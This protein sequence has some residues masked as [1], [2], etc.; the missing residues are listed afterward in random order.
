VFVKIPT[1]FEDVFRPGRPIDQ[2]K[3]L[4]GREQQVWDFERSLGRPGEHI[5]VVGYRGAGKTSLWQM[6]LK[7]RGFV[8][9]TCDSRSTFTHVFGNLLGKLGVK[10]LDRE[11]SQDVSKE[12]GAKLKLGVLEGGGKYT[13]SDGTKETTKAPTE[14]NPGDVYELL[15]ST[16]VK[17]PILVLDE[18]DRVHGT[19]KTEAFIDGIADLMKICSDHSNERDVK[20]VVVGTMNTAQQLL[21]MHDSITRCAR[22]IYVPL[23]QHE[24]IFDFLSQA[25]HDLN[26]Q[27]CQGVKQSLAN[28]SL[29]FPAFF[30]RV[31]RSSI[32]AMYRR[33]PAAREVTRKDFE[34]GVVAACDEAFRFELNE[35]S[36]AIL[37][38]LPAERAIIAELVD[39]R[40]RFPQRRDLKKAVMGRHSI[41]DVEFDA[42]L[43]RLSQEKKL[44]YISSS[45]DRVAFRNPLLKP[46]IRSL[47]R[48]GY[49]F[50]EADGSN[51]RDLFERETGSDETDIPVT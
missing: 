34:V 14:L 50:H 12:G 45:N 20:L 10:L 19:A 16:T 48:R 44:L 26:I 11:V 13:E 24:H 23:L 15:V 1:D 42:T 30:H 36:A 31:G 41:D 49:T 3:Y 46:F 5:V 17:Q 18:F 4:L 27:F 32:T 21:G 37:N 39:N 2:R 40:E 9:R 38:A 22:E 8:D 6:S 28:E 33:D 7:G 47:A 35:Y 25:E 43:L 51:Q 29:G